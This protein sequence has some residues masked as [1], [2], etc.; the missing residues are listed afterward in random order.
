VG[1]YK[2]HSLSREPHSRKEP[3]GD[4]GLATVL[5]QCCYSAASVLPQCCYSAFS[6]GAEDEVSEHSV[7]PSVQES[8]VNM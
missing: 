2:R 8:Q 7:R 3:S 6:A 1:Q 5:L 4:T